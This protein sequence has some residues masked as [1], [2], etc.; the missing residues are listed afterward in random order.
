MTAKKTAKSLFKSGASALVACLASVSLVAAQQG[1]PENR[2]GLPA[3]YSGPASAV[4]AIVNDKVITTFDVQQRMKLMLISAGGR[5]TPQMLPQLQRQAM[6]DLVEEQLKFQEAKEFDL[7]PEEGE[8]DAEL[9]RMAAQTGMT[10]DQFTGV[11]S[12]ED[13]SVETLKNQIAASI[14]WPRLVSGRY[15]KRVRVD[16]EEVESTIERMRADA[17]QEQFM[18]SEICIPIPSPDQAQA[19]YD[20]SLQLLEQ[21]RKGVPFAVIAQQ[22]SACTTAAAGGD[23]GWMR[24]GE[25]PPDLDAAVRDLPVGAV[26]NPILSDNAFMILAVRDKRAAVSQGE[27]SWTFAYASTPLSTGRAAARTALEKLKTAEACSGG[28]TLRQDLGAGVDV[29]IIENATL[30]M[31][32]ERFR[33]A[34]ENLSRRE[35]SEIVEADDALHIL[36]ACE[37]DEGL[38]IPSREAV[39]DRIYSRQLERIAQQYL[40]DVERK[41]TVDVRLVTPGQG[42]QRGNSANNG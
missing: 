24:A 26:T 2:E 9:R 20:G 34:V 7:A 1:A 32:D 40:R 17:T 28:R 37:V 39:E 12:S 42:E 16:P 22:F 6:R 31:I 11:L 41:S 19:Y 5:I 8:V 29:A 27:K 18:I 21:M 36:Y 13:V 35:L 23:M 10:V 38:G 15:G 4:A 25:L 30:S 33:P 14:V 3:T